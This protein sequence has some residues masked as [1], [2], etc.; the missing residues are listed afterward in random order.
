MLEALLESMFEEILERLSNA[1][2]ISGREEEV[3]EI[4]RKHGDF[5]GD[6][7]GNLFAKKGSG[8]KLMLVAHMDEVGFMVK[9]IGDD[10]FIWFEKVG[11]VEDSLLEGT[12][13]LC[14]GVRGVIGSYPPHVREKITAKESFMDFGFS[15]GK[16]A[17]DAGIRTGMS[18]CFA[19]R[20]SS[21]GNTM[22]GKALDDRIGCA[23]ILELVER[24]D[25]PAYETY[26]AFSTQEE[27]GSRGARAL[28]EEIRP[29]YVI[30]VEG[31]SAA[32]VPG[33]KAQDVPAVIGMGPAITVM[34]KSLIASEDMVE[35]LIGCAD[36]YQIK[37]PA[38]GGTDAGIAFGAKATVCAVPCRYIHAP[39]SI[40]RKDDVEETLKMLEGFLK[41]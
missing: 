32:D 35:K 17:E 40:A 36:R 31:T 11:G 39:L 34:D 19:T 21:R 33:M 2:G 15:S 8:R 14:N 20:F 7:A 4:I 41:S 5:S 23:I 13:V 25:D 28:V 27:V 26:F 24:V 1:R 16:E 22:M 6:N 9:H 37:K 18:I 30:A 12:E 10:G 38:Y 29:E 3:R